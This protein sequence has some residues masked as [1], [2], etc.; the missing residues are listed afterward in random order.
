VNNVLSI[1]E[2]DTF[3]AS[4]FK[5]NLSVMGRGCWE[6]KKKNVAYIRT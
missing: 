6:V 5:C 2:C 3:R 4:K 1:N